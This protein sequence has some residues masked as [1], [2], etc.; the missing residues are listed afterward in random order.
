MTRRVIYTPRSQRDLE[1]I[2][3]YITHESGSEQPA[4]RFL[5]QLLDACDSLENL[6]ERYPPYPFFPRWRMMPTGNY[7]IFFKV[8]AATVSIG[9][10]RHGAMKP[11]SR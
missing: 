8:E 2:R 4:L 9:H 5:R 3:A 6:P 1:K 10:I 11:F 7:L